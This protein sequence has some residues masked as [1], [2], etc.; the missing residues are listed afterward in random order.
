[1]NT[2]TR[3]IRITVARTRRRFRA[4]RTAAGDAGMTTAEYAMGTF[5]AVGLA[6]VL[7]KVVTGGSIGAMIEG[8]I[9]KA[10]DAH[11]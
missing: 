2:A 11:F 4:V 8:V 6:I 7:Y 5:A 10:L 3:L 9:K 1:M